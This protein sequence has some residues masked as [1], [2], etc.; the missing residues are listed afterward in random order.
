M[1]SYPQYATS[2][3][4]KHASVVVVVVVV[5]VVEV[6]EEVVGAAV[7]P[8]ISGMTIADR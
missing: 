3:S 6:V 2:N 7:G 4:V 5:V 1:S 8:Q